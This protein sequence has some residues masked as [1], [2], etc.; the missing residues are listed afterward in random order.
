[1]S[2]QTIERGRKSI[3][4]TLNPVY[5]GVGVQYMASAKTLLR[6]SPSMSTIT[7]PR[8][9][10]C[11]GNESGSM[12]PRG[13]FKHLSFKSTSLSNEPGAL[14]GPVVPAVC[15]DGTVSRQLKSREPGGKVRR[16]ALYVYGGLV[17]ETQTLEAR[18]R[19]NS[20]K[21]NT[22]GPCLVSL[23]LGRVRRLV[24]DFD[25]R[26]KV[27]AYFPYLWVHCCSPERPQTR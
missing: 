17:A 12:E 8:G 21:E 10:D 11:L 14:L 23:V 13:P 4:I 24:G 7:S 22:N 15:I 27:V 19:F 16:R 18:G 6:C 26:P 25:I 5:Q 1:M 2:K 20:R 9:H 3:P